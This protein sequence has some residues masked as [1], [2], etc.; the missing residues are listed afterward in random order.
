MTSNILSRQ[1]E[2][3]MYQTTDV[4]EFQELLDCLSYVPSVIEM[5]CTIP[6]LIVKETV[7]QAYHVKRPVKM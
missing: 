2:L 6:E 5:C 3:M 4:N 1:Y 7:V